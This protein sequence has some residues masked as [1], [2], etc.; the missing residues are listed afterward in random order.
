[1]QYATLSRTDKY[2][3]QILFVDTIQS[4]IDY[5]GD[6]QSLEDE[7]VARGV[8]LQ[9]VLELYQRAM[10]SQGGAEMQSSGEE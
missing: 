3:Y 4:Y 5:G 8:N 7:I 1:M 2:I 9:R 10:S 6:L